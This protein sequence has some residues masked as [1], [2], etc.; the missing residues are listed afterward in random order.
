MN[1]G[2]MDQRTHLDERSHIARILGSEGYG[3]MVA[4]RELIEEIRGSLRSALESTQ[5]AE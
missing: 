5:A 2:K 1:S 3:L 4:P